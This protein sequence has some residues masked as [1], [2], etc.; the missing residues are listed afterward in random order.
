VI[1]ISWF[2]DEFERADLAFIYR[3]AAPDGE[4]DIYHEFIKHLAVPDVTC[5]KSPAGQAAESVR[6][7][8][9]LRNAR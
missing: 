1:A 3:D 8:G 4:L 9:L 7:V 5:R 2:F 6:P